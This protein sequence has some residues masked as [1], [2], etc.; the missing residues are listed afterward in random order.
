MQH[1]K[2]AIKILLKKTG[3]EGGVKQQEVI[4]VWEEV[5]GLTISKNTKPTSIR[6]GVL[7]VEVSKHTWK[8]ELQFQKN[9][10]IKKINTKLNNKLLK[11]IRFK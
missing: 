9:E 6:H 1:I 2:Q 11:E 4:N 5:V 7:I 3:L 8:Q 10:I